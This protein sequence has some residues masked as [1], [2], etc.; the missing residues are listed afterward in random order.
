MLAQFS[1]VDKIR[2]RV[3]ALLA[4]FISTASL[5]GQ[6][7]RTVIE[8]TFPTTCT[9]LAAQQAIVSGEPA[10]ETTFDTTRIQTALTA[11]P[12]GQAVELTAGGTNNG[13][14]A[15]LTGPLNIPSGVTLVVDGGVTLFG[16][17]NPADYQSTA[18][19]AETCGTVG[20]LGNGCNPLIQINSGTASTG[21]GVM[22]FGIINGRGGDKL[23][24]NGVTQTISWW[25]LGTQANGN[26]NQNNPMLLYAKN[27]ANFT[28]YKISF[29]NAPLY[30]V[31][32][33]TASGLTIWGIKIVTPYTARNTDGIDPADKV[34]N[35]T[36]ANSYVSDGE[37]NIA[38]SANGTGNGVSNVTISNLHTYSGRGV[39]IGTYTSGGVSNVF[40]NNLNMTGNLADTN[41][42]GIRIRSSQ[43]RG[44]LVNNVS[45]NNVCV[46]N[47][48]FPL[49]FNPAS[50]TNAGTSFPTYQNIAL[51]G[52]SI[53][54]VAAGQSQL[55]GYSVNFPL[56]LQM[57]NLNVTGNFPAL[58]P[59][60]QFV[61]FIVGP[62]PVNPTALQLIRGTGVT[63]TGNITNP[64][65]AAHACPVS[66][67]PFLAGE[68]YLSTSTLT[69]KQTVSLPNPA[70][71]TLNAVVEPVEAASVTPTSA[72]QFYE[73]TVLVG[74]AAL[75]S[76][77]TLA[78]LTL[79]G[80]TS[81]AHTYTARYP[82][83]SAYALLNFGSVTVNVNTTATTTAMTAT[84]VSALYGNT[85][86]LVATVTPASGTTNPTGTVTFSNG[87][88]VFGTATLVAGVATLNTTTLPVGN[89]AILAAYGGS[90]NFA[91]SNSNAAPVNVSISQAGTNTTVGAAPA[92]T[93]YGGTV[94]LTSVV[95]A[96]TS[97]IPTGSVTFMDGA[98]IL[99]TATLSI[100]TQANTGSA[101]LAVTNL[102]TGFHSITAVYGGDTNFTSS[103]SPSSAPE[104]VFTAS[105]TTALGFTSGSVPYGGAVTMAA[106][107]NA[108][109]ATA[110]TGT[111]TFTDTSTTPSTPLATV[112]IT[113]G[114][115]GASYTT[116]SLTVGTHTIVATYSGDSNYTGS[117]SS[118]TPLVVTLAASS[119]T[120]SATGTAII[121]GTSD[122]ITATVSPSTSGVPSGTVTFKDGATVIGT[123][124]LFGSTAS[125]TPSILAGGTHTITIVYSG[126]S[127]FAASTSSPLV[128][129]V[130]AAASTTA[131]SVPAPITYGSAALLS[132]TVTSS[133]PG[134]LTGTVT[135]KDGATVLGTGTLSAGTASF[136]AAALTGGTH[137][138]TAVYS[139]DANYATSISAGA[140]LTVNKAGTTS[141]VGATTPVITYGASEVLTATVTPMTASGTFTFQDGGVTIGTG[142]ISNGTASFSTTALAAGAHTITAIYSGD[143]NYLTSTSAT[144][145]TVTVTQV[146]PT[147]T[148]TANPGNITFGSST[149]LTATI[150]PAAAT[151][152]VTFTDSVNG[153]LGTGTVTNGAATISVATLTA[154]SHLITATY[155]GDLNDTAATSAPAT[156]N[157]ALF[158]TTTTVAAAPAT[159]AFGA[160]TTLSAIVSPASVTGSV[161][162]KDGA[163][164]LQTV[165]VL[166]GAASISVSTLAVGSHS[167]TATY[168][169]DTN[170]ATS[171][172]AAATV[173]VTL[174][175]TTTTIS[176]PATGSYG[177]PTLIAVTIAPSAAT[178]TVTFKDGATTIGTT[179]V[180]SGTATFSALLSAGTHTLSAS[181]S[182]DANYAASA[183]TAS[184]SVV[185]AVATTSV[186]VSGNPVAVPFGSATTLTASVTPSA[187]TGTIVFR[188]TSTG[189]TLGTAS[190]SGGAASLS[191]ILLSPAGAHTITATYSGDVND[192]A[193]TSPVATVNVTPGP[194]QVTLSNTP[195]SPVMYGTSV[196][197]S[198]V[199]TTILGVA[200]TGTVQY[201]DGATVL[202]SAPITLNAS[203]VPVSTFLLATLAPGTHTLTA[204]Y[205][206]DGNYA[207]ST[208]AAISFTVTQTNSTTTLISNPPQTTPGQT[209]TLTAT[210]ASTAGAGTPTGTITFFDQNNVSLGTVPLTGGSASIQQTLTALGTYT[211][212][213]SYSG[214]V[215][216]NASSSAATPTTVIVKQLASTIS[217]SAT[218]TSG[219]FGVGTY[220]VTAIVTPA[221]GGPAT[222][223]VTFNDGAT[224][225][226][227]VALPTSDTVSLTNITLAG[228]VHS[229]TAT[230][231]GDPIYVSS[232]SLTPATITVNTAASAISVSA[233][234][235]TSAFG[236]SVA[237]SAAVTSSTSTVATG[238]VTFKNGS[239]VLGTGTLNA[240]GIA[241]FSTS[242]LPIAVYNVTAVY[243]G[244]PNF[245]PSTSAATT[246]TVTQIPQTITL[247]SLPASVTYGATPITLT[248]TASSTL[249]VTLAV[250]GPATLNGSILSFTGAGTVT[251]TATQAGNATY[252]A[253]TP[254]V[255]T[256]IVAKAPLTVSVANQSITSGAAIPSLTGTL[257][258]VVNGDAIT[259]SYST[260]ATIA[261]APGT[262]PITAT[263]VDPGNR[264]GNYT[265]TNTPATLTILSSGQTITFATIPTA[266]I[267][268]AGA[269]TLSATAS[270]GLPVALS[271][272]GPATLN[273][274]TLTYSGAGTVV[275]TATQ[276]GNTIYP[277]ATSVVQTVVVA[278]APLTVT[279]ANA[280]RAYNT[281]NP[282]LTGTLTG[283]V[284]GDAI[285][286][287][288]ST[289]A[290]AS[291]APGTY[292]ITPTLVDPNNRLVNYAVTTTAGTLTVTTGSTSVSLTLSATT[293]FANSA[294]TLTAT[295]ASPSGA[296][297][298]GTVTFLNGPTTLGTATVTN[299]VASVTVTNLAVGS[300]TVTAS[301]A[302]TTNY[303]ASVSGPATLTVVAPVVLTLSPASV[304]VA[305][306]GTGT[307]TLTLAPSAGFT[308]AVTLTCTSPVAYVT[309]T[310]TSP[311]TISGTTSGTATV[312]I[313]VPATFGTLR[314]PQIGPERGPGVVAL[315]SLLPFGALL[316]VPLIGR[317]RKLLLHRGIRLLALF[318]VAAG[319]SLAVTGCAGG[320]S[321]APHLPP[322]GSQ[323]VTITAVANSTTVTTPLTVVVTN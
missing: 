103:T 53:V 298:T 6:D 323:T 102:N 132:A 190:L 153:V 124:T 47:I 276:A 147:V 208:G 273:G 13:N 28:L 109:T 219:T 158:P 216:F 95:A 36:I 215:N 264:L 238:T 60:P 68:L 233:T 299:G 111:I 282:T 70:T 157:V 176:A 27:A 115:S 119:T 25:D 93:V 7:T 40:V 91:T 231:N 118:A 156:V 253:A 104:T 18:S 15:F 200:P 128:I 184:A 49:M 116:S 302:A 145:A 214:D 69:N 167:I 94:T 24:K 4:F 245:A 50:N 257:T 277:A 74:N 85:V 303:A 161:T 198:T 77:G 269:V 59:A 196:T 123:Q 201:L 192:G 141:G 234:P 44:G 173:T 23:I 121:Y 314:I 12:A 106:T 79:S 20:T 170:N 210:A 178:G 99:G 292:P 175:P 100:G 217:V 96:A 194:T 300:Y 205:L 155:S 83:D 179:T 22:G 88:T 92:N 255:S 242:T 212:T 125:I 136:S 193:S 43:D 318:L 87:S 268:G 222:G 247:S 317:R 64:S 8:P 301:F 309:C 209:F 2:L 246:V 262:Y 297:A 279:G 237:F 57:D 72:I 142:T 113:A 39:S 1:L 139:G 82:A 171:T 144:A 112:A 164:V 272:T 285:T 11:C 89:N 221:S 189:L 321:I 105:T 218:P 223:S 211:Y 148:L 240:S 138:I 307:S 304:T 14:N 34:N 127:N 131:V 38:L 313:N 261:S 284:N 294:E 207:T 78:S 48:R 172:S 232:V 180:A 45:Y 81:G 154:G 287:T 320:G 98:T 134:A 195:V 30:H 177:T 183:T 283:V 322:A 152:N 244:D 213:S 202:G 185:I 117:S 311:V 130:S 220:T 31:K 249:T 293:I 296:P 90:S 295:V 63:Y 286:A 129:T 259:A 203:S 114:A 67:F 149:T 66:N 241:S 162:F 75:G 191:G 256:I 126:D 252:A 65:A 206:G 182:G 243:S 143:G 225:L 181:Y 42:V 275:V 224:I 160:S 187:A 10:S 281:A 52:V 46:Q 229:I 263:L 258:G 251:V 41:A 76:N 188:D 239:T 33:T 316:L 120:A 51:H 19:G 278:K 35:V 29:L 101:Q 26:G 165:P 250:T 271:V 310:V 3:V 197:L 227:T 108:S 54:G 226:G 266:V 270:S 305:P 236:T 135:F 306:G 5:Y 137:S 267:Y 9:A 168:S 146:T 140:T 84:P 204:V 58:T 133:T 291:S 186:V 32:Y 288:Y 163:T 55:Q 166:G 107:I 71:F 61:N 280:S 235:A 97:G 122:T 289:T 254:V 80:V 319:M 150:L 56:N 86:A 265:V 151:G 199:N 159:I 16:S 17:R 290:I 110:A 37:D 21:S 260:T 169:G 248:A 228:G 315:A 62:G 312:T 308:G 230:Y 73:G 174:A 274:S